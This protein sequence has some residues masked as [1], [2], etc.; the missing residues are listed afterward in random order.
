MTAQP[1]SERTF[2]VLI[3]DRDGEHIQ[4][5]ARL[6]SALDYVALLCRQGHDA[7]LLTE[8]ERMKK[9]ASLAGARLAPF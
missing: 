5:F 4:E 9:G 1:A 7:R 2:A 8:T 6:T 3:T